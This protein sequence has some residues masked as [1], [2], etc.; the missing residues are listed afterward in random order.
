[1]A[2]ICALLGNWR[3]VICFYIHD[4]GTRKSPR[5]FIYAHIWIYAVRSGFEDTLLRT[6][7]EHVQHL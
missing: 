2:V 1:M 4:I 6:E 7:K 3:Y 5:K